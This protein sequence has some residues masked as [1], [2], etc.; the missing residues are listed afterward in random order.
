M[1]STLVAGALLSVGIVQ[2]T[3]T[4]FA[5][6]SGARLDF[7]SMGGDL[8]VRTWNRG[9]VRVVSDPDDR[10][11]IEITTVGQVVKIRPRA[12]RGP[13]RAVD[14]HITVPVSMS[15]DVNGTYL[16][17]DVE[18][19]RGEVN[20]ET[21]QGDVRL[22]GG[23]GV[24][25]VRSVQGDVDVRDVEGRVS[26]GSVNGDVRLTDAMGGVTAE[27]VNGDITLDRVR[28]S[29]VGA[30]TTNGD[31]RYEGTIERNGR[32][33]FSTHNGDLTV[34]VP[35]RANA[36]VSVSTFNGEFESS[37]P[38]TLT[39]TRS[40]GKRFTFV[41]GD[42]SARIEL[43]S[44]GGTIRLRRPGEATRPRRRR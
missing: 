22:V 30:T 12:W 41:L 24:V 35:E 23:R 15:V 16:E 5:V 36:T 37:F 39:E 13:A 3:D 4:T 42:G 27:T 9:A 40:G 34:S 43:D 21:V 7:H 17:V 18:G 1:F 26:V 38:V 31:V 14:V 20:V 33:T 19:V 29:S 44:F 6:R 25:T 8:V 32:Y 28:S 10:E 2:Q 11:R